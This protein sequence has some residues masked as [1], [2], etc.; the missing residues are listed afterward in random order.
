MVV[1]VDDYLL[2]SSKTWICGCRGERI[3]NMTHLEA[4]G[5]LGGQ[6]YAHNDNLRP[7]TTPW[8]TV[9]GVQ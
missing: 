4:E 2:G 1:P 6:D 3:I 5:H 7:S 9:F 8:T